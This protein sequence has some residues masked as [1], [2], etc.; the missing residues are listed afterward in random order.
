MRYPNEITL[1]TGIKALSGKSVI[2]KPE[3]TSPSG[4]DDEYTDQ[5]K[6]FFLNDLG[7]S[8]DLTLNLSY[9][10]KVDIGG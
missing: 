9:S 4:N 1:V 2:I 3:I 7:A 5:L 6:S 10:E 8:K